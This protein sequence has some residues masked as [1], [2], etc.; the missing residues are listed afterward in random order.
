M[1]RA[2]AV[3]KQIE[4]TRAVKGVLKA[5][6]KVSRAEI[7]PTGQIVVICGEDETGQSSFEK[8]KKERGYK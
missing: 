1:H 5:G 8:W 2:P 3:F 4:V 7:A 6:L